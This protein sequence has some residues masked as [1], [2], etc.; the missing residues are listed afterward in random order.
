MKDYNVMIDGKNVLINQQIMI[1][2]YIKIL[3]NCYW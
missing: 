1:L 2:K 3:E